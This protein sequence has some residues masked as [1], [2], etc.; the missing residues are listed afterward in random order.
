MNPTKTLELTLRTPSKEADELRR[1][2]MGLS[3][4]QLLD[5]V[6]PQRCAYRPVAVELAAAELQ[7][8]GVTQ[9]AADSSEALLKKESPEPTGLLVPLLASLNVTAMLIALV[10]AGVLL[11]MIM[12]WFPRLGNLA[13]LWWLII[14]GCSIVAFIF[15]MLFEGLSKL[16]DKSRLR[17]KA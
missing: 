12:Q 14:G 13:G 4:E 15:E 5:I 8:R 16:L 10:G 6:G 17:R 2:M 1:R 7:Q 3:D 11:T 9:P